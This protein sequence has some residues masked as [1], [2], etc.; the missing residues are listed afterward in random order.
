MKKLGT[1]NLILLGGF[2]LIVV[3]GVA[4]LMLPAPGEA[5]QVVVTPAPEGAID[6]VTYTKENCVGDE[7]LAVAGLVYPVEGLTQEEEGILLRSLDDAYK[8]IA[9]N[10]AAL[11]EFGDVMPFI[12]IVRIEQHYLAAQKALFDKYG[13]E[14]PEN[15]RFDD[16]II[17][18]GLTK[19]EAC[20][21][22]AEFERQSIE[23][24]DTQLLPGV[25]ERPDIYKVLSAIN[26]AS[27]DLHRN[28]YLSC[29]E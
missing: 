19:E 22:L 27:R 20:A 9:L 12:N 4:L 25:S 24:Y 7:C 14:I 16:A 26:R 13:I 21:A 17:P 2:G 1:K 10:S 6:T 15:S 5:P 28:A 3:L 8:G 23:L 18:E 11:L 29:S